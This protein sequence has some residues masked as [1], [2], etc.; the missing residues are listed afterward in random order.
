MGQVTQHE[1]TPIVDAIECEL[2]S[3]SRRGSFVPAV[4]HL[5]RHVLLFA[6]TGANF[7]RDHDLDRSTEI[8]FRSVT[9]GVPVVP[10]PHYLHSDSGA[11]WRG[12]HMLLASITKN[13]I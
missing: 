4:S 6:L 5:V 11:L 10:P 8:D 1:L 9:G 2:V 13:G 3:R 7:T 12:D